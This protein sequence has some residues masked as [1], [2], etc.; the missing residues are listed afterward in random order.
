MAAGVAVAAATVLVGVVAVHRLGTPPPPRAPGE[1]V[2]SFL[3]VGQG[4]AVLLQ[5]DATSVLVDTGPPGGP[6][7]RRLAEAGVERLDLLVLTHAEA[8]HEGMALPVIEAHRPRMVLDGGAG[9]PTAVQRDLPA[10]LAHAGG[11]PVA[12]HAGQVLRLGPLK[13]NV[14]WP[15]APAPG[16]R[17]DGNPNDRAVVAHVQDG[18]FDLLLPA[19]AESNVTAGLDLP[20][21]E[22]LKVAHHGSVDDGLPAL[23]ERTA[24]RIAAIEVGPQQLRPPGAV[25]A[26]RAARGARGRP[27]RPR[28]D[29]AAA[30]GRRWRDAHGGRGVSARVG[31]ARADRVTACASA[32]GV[33]ARAPA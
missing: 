32:D 10:A 11:R 7:L 17:P 8:D 14:L 30:R 5:R 13:L 4:D 33:T 2:V 20:R 25:D 9:W 12:A 27:D 6:I 22:A 1:L 31:G 26:R 15:P 18:T 23:L 21:V 28:R 29:G 24:P 3:D 16:W 19:D